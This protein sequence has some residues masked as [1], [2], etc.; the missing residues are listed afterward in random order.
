MKQDP[1]LAAVTA[2]L[3]VLTASMIALLFWRPFGQEQAVT[4]MNL[5]VVEQLGLF[6]TALFGALSKAWLDVVTSDRDRTRRGGHCQS[7]E[8]VRDRDAIHQCIGCN[9]SITRDPQDNC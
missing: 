8:Y 2:L 7:D 1:I 5:H 6:W 4:D 9:N 3:F